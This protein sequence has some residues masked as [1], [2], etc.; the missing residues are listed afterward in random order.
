M[1]SMSRL[2]VA[3]AGLLIHK[4]DFS[5]NCRKGKKVHSVTTPM[6]ANENAKSC[7]A[8]TLTDLAIRARDVNVAAEDG[9]LLALCPE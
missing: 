3:I 7:N 4:I 2:S 6:V 9:R 8:G 1:R 5:G